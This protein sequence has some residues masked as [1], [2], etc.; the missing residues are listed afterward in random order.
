VQ[1]QFSSKLFKSVRGP[2]IFP[3]LKNEKRKKTG[4]VHFLRL[5]FRQKFEA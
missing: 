5:A 1:K 4:M 3:S 2:F